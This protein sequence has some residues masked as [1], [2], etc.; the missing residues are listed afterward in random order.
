MGLYVSNEIIL[1]VVA[2]LTYYN[3]RARSNRERYVWGIVPVLL[4]RYLLLSFFIKNGEFLFV[5]HSMLSVYYVLFLIKKVDICLDNKNKL[6]T[7]AP[8]LQESNGLMFDV[9]L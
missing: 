1:P 5:C 7:F 8:A 2:N 9:L 3:R 4:I 6:S